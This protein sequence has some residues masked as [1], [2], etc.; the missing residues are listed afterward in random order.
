MFVKGSSTLW[1]LF[2]I[3]CSHYRATYIGCKSKP[4]LYLKTIN[5]KLSNCVRVEI[6]PINKLLILCIVGLVLCVHEMLLLQLTYFVLFEFD[7]LLPVLSA[8]V[9]RDSLEKDMC[10]TRANAI[11]I[12]S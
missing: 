6:N 2:G 7:D 5:C 9:M 8:W 11:D 3:Q 1:L 10:L 12:S 4:M